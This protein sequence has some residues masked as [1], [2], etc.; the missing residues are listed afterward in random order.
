MKVNT[1]RSSEIFDEFIKNYSTYK[2]GVD[3]GTKSRI[4]KIA[5]SS[6]IIKIA[7]LRAGV[8]LASGVA[9]AGGTIAIAG[10]VIGNLADVVKHVDVL[11]IG[12]WAK[13]VGAA[14]NLPS[15]MSRLRAGAV[16]DASSEGAGEL[17]KLSSMVSKFD[18]VATNA[19]KNSD[20]MINF[21]KTSSAA[22]P[23]GK[24][25]WVGDLETAITRVYIQGTIDAVGTGKSASKIMEDSITEVIRN[26]GANFRYE[27][28]GS[29]AGWKNI[30]SRQPE[31]IDAVEGMVKGTARV[32][33]DELAGMYRRAGSARKGGEGGADLRQGGARE[34]TRGEGGIET[35]VAR[36]TDEA[37][38]AGAG[39]AKGTDDVDIRDPGVPSR[40]DNPQQIDQLGATTAKNA[41]DIAAI[42]RFNETMR[43]QVGQS[44]NLEQ[45]MALFQDMSRTQQETVREMARSMGSQ[46]VTVKQI[47]QQS[48]DGAV[49]GAGRKASAR[50][51]ETSRKASDGIP[52][53]KQRLR[54]AQAGGNQADITR[55]QDEIRRLEEITRRSNAGTQAVK[56]TAGWKALIPGS[57]ATAWKWG[58]RILVGGVLIG[59]GYLLYQWLTGPDGDEAFLRVKN[60]TIQPQLIEDPAGRLVPVVEAAI[61]ALRAVEFTPA[62]VSDAR[63]GAYIEFLQNTLLPAVSSVAQDGRNFALP[64]GNEN[65]LI[66][67]G[68]ATSNTEAQHLAMQPAGSF[69]PDVVSGDEAD[70]IAAEDAVENLKNE[71]QRF[72]ESV[73][74]T[75]TDG[76]QAQAGDNANLGNR[77]WN[78]RGGGGQVG[79]GGAS[80]VGGAPG[81]RGQQGGGSGL[82]GRRDP[83]G[84]GDLRRNEIALEMDLWGETWRVVL[85]ARS[86]RIGGQRV[87]TLRSD[88]AEKLGDPPPDG[89]RPGPIYRALNTAIGKEYVGLGENNDPQIGGGH[90]DWSNIMQSDQVRLNDATGARISLAIQRMARYNIDSVKELRKDLLEDSKDRLGEGLFNTSPAYRDEKRSL[91]APTRES[92]RQERKD[93]KRRRR[94]SRRRA[95]LDISGLHKVSNKKSLYESTNIDDLIE[96][97]IQYNMSFNKKADKYS[98]EYFRDAVKGLNDS[99]VKTYYAGFKDMYNERPEKRPKDTNSLYMIGDETGSEL[100]QRAHPKSIVVSDAMGNGGLV[101][102]LLEQHRHG[103]EVAFST[104]T[105][106]Y[107]SKHAYVLEELKGLAKMARSENNAEAFEMIKGAMVEIV[108]LNPKLV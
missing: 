19:I 82:E 65:G 100:V 15:I 37:G 108:S 61:T 47:N 32:E 77:D 102:N 78:P 106:N 20:E 80:G 99:S 98:N 28:P 62:S 104:P 12:V 107:R 36:Y 42:S 30:A 1:S 51:R 16:I 54:Q 93:R 6:R 5:G 17:A 96:T 94:E 7:S 43:G 59:A 68:Q 44:M 87:S 8:Q 89:T 91:R 63:T 86:R 25:T 27:L 71:L 105:G 69:E 29:I 9:D 55:L 84:R 46:S 76:M 14:D 38:D 103:E 2:S 11:P 41:E 85:P 95:G 101:E 4:S 10:K 90:S 13:A 48:V 33:P 39:A 75:L 53:R 92:R 52:R 83:G 49:T 74:K 45:V 26:G 23:G 70:F 22:F 88:I 18:Q 50:A 35:G 57:A 72:S 64:E 40:V 21:R 34:L 73:S 24:N 3:T 31:F 81:Q 97:R 66:I 56:E 60:A 58:K 79:S 67:T